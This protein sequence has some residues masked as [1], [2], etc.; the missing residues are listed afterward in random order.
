MHVKVRNHKGAKS[1]RGP[2][3]HTGDSFRSP[4]VDHLHFIEVRL[5]HFDEF[6]VLG[7]WQVHFSVC[8]RLERYEEAMRKAIRKSLWAVVGSIFKG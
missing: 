5:K 3:C 6:F 8:F 7:V 1:R 4:I 2:P